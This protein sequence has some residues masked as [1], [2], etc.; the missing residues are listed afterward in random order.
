M[1]WIE[2]NLPFTLR[3]HQTCFSLA[4]IKE[5][6]H[7]LTSGYEGVQKSD[8]LAKGNNIAIIGN[9]NKPIMVY[10][11]ELGILPPHSN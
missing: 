3:N 5:L 1:G 9:I 7:V 4:Q 10:F 11:P 2:K 6:G 8:Y